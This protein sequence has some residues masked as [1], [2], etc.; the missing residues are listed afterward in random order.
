MSE[1]CCLQIPHEF[2]THIIEMLCRPFKYA[3]H[4]IPMNPRYSLRGTNSIAFDQRFKYLHYLFMGSFQIKESSPFTLRK[5]SATF[6]TDRFMNML[7]RSI[8]SMYFDVAFS[9][10]HIQWAFFIVAHLPGKIVL[11]FLSHRSYPFL[12]SKRIFEES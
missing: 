12:V 4:C 5:Q 10:L 7:I 3:R 8:V 1:R 2:F 11:M 6:D 9:L